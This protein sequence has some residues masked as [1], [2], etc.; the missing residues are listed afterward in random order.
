MKITINRNQVNY[1][2]DGPP[3]A[4]VV[5][6]SHAL[7]TNLTLWD[8][9]IDA[10][11]RNFRLLRYDSLGHGGTDAPSGPYTLD[12][13]AELAGGL[14]DALN[15][16]PVHFLGISM[17]GMIGQALALA[18]PQVLA[19]L[20][21]CDTSSRTPAEAQPLWKERIK[22]A[23]EEGME[24]LVE[25]T[26]GRW[27]TP[28]FRAARPEVVERVRGMIRGTAPAGYIGCCHAIA[29]LDLAPRISAIKL[30]AIIIVG[31]DDPGTSAAMA[32]AIHE[33]ISG[34]ELVTI[35]RASH[36]SN[37]EQTE[38]FNQVVM[39]FLSRFA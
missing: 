33:Q 36:L 11:S 18:R 30:P 23:T 39:T 32:R 5:M 1:V 9:Q 3:S 34:S 19:S 22:V 26:I 35:P 17:G 12:Q 13:L 38:K 7:A 10:L 31:A 29:A 15:M 21:L 37:I 27:F 20:M 14:L 8:S 16:R 24:P 6:M 28:P 2:L 4:P 25:P